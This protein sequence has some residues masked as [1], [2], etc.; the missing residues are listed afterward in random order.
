M[1]QLYHNVRFLRGA[2]L[3]LKTVTQ[4][5]S[6][7]RNSANGGRGA[8]RWRYEGVGGFHSAWDLQVPVCEK[9]AHRAQLG[10]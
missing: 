5:H 9:E 10:A 8:S 1:K 4:L 2:Q 6:K 3:I 7:A